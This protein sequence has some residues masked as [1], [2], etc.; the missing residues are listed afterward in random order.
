[1]TAGYQRL[2]EKHNACT[3]KAEQEN[4]EL[5]KTH[6]AELYKL[7][8][9]LDLETRSY[10]EYRQNVC[11]RLHELHEMVASSFD[12]VKAQCLPFPGKGTKI[13][14]MIDWVAGE[15]K[16]MLDTVWQLNDNFAVLGIEGV[17]TM[18]NDK[19]CQE[20]GQLHDLAA[21]H[22]AAVLQDVPEDVRKL[23]RRIM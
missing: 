1:V 21:S 23:D 9:Y 3:A 16:T 18:L 10:T 13:E 12:E 2:A 4:T 17:L 5:A 15:V 22:D 7:R 14:E 6:V 20:L 19:G 11:R 8:G